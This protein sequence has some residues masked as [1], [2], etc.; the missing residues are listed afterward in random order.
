MED[1]NKGNWKFIFFLTV[2]LER[3]YFCNLSPG[4]FPPESKFGYF[5]KLQNTR[6]TSKVLHCWSILH[7]KSTNGPHSNQ[8]KYSPCFKLLFEII[9]TFSQAFFHIDRRACWF[10]RHTTPG[11]VLLKDSSS[12]RSNYKENW[13][14]KTFP[15]EEGTL[16]WYWDLKA[17]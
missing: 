6:C 11:V 8:K 2:R 1:F 13:Y 16:K 4:N 5:F 10:L 3:F 12:S 14:A 15:Y 7:E 17:K 9:T